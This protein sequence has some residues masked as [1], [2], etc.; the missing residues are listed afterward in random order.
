[1]RE[2]TFFTTQARLIAVDARYAYLPLITKE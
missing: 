2:G 1:M